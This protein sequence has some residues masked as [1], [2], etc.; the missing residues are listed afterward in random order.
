[1][2]TLDGLTR[3]TSVLTH[4]DVDNLKFSVYLVGDTSALAHSH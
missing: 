2:W 1:M 3:A 4:R